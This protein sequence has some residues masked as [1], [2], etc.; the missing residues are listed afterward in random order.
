MPDM[1]FSCLNL[2]HVYHEQVGTALCT[3]M[4]QAVT[5]AMARWAA[6]Y[7]I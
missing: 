2:A 6:L 3:L 5:L 4:K 7:Y 1:M